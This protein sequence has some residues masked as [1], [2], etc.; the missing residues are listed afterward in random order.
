LRKAA[1]FDSSRNKHGQ[2]LPCT[3]GEFGGLVSKR[4][5]KG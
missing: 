5:N 4:L 2:D 1:S 3:G